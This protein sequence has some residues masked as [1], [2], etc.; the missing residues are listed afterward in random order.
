MPYIRKSL[1]LA[2][3]IL[4]LLH[5]ITPALACS[6]GGNIPLQDRI[7]ASDYVAKVRV[8]ETDEVGRNVIVE[9]ESYLSGEAGPSHLFIGGMPPS[10]VQRT[11]IDRAPSEECGGYKGAFDEL[12][13]GDTFY[14]VLAHTPLG[15]YYGVP[16][17]LFNADFIQFPTPDSTVFVVFPDGEF[18]DSVTEPEFLDIVADI[19]GSSPLPPLP[20]S[21]YP[22]RSPL[23]ITTQSGADY[24][25]PLD[26]GEPLLIT[27]QVLSDVI[28]S[29]YMARTPW[30]MWGERLFPLLAS[31]PDMD[32]FALHPLNTAFLPGEDRILLT[33]GRE[34]EL[35]GQQILVSPAAEAAA[36][37]NGDT[38]NVYLL[39]TFIP[40]LHYRQPS[41]NPFPDVTEVPYL[42]GGI[43]LDSAEDAPI[44]SAY[45]AWSP[46]ARLLAYSDAQSLWLWDALGGESPRLL[47]P[48]EG[49]SIPYARYFSPGGRYLAVTA[50]DRA[51]NLDL[52]SGGEHPDGQFSSD[53]RLLL[54]LRPAETPGF[55]DLAIQQMT[56]P[57]EYVPFGEGV[58]VRQAEWLEDGWFLTVQCLE[59]EL[60]TCR[61]L[62][63]KVTGETHPDGKGG[64]LTYPGT[65]FVVEDGSIATLVNGDTITFNG[66][67]L[68]LAL[69]SPIARIRWM[70]TLFYHRR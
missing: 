21:P 60:S 55:Y 57:G 22:A 69:D 12:H 17:V 29:G 47:L 59:Q 39:R 38:L 44:G 62:P 23:L 40:F 51:Y 33:W 56:P 6:G 52:I 42:L 67:L 11:L 2:A 24:L 30:S 46:D 5:P 66:T 27:E 1:F 68:D 15:K 9:V 20:D 36:V 64:T 32:C 35:V 53:D 14:A 28:L 31:C 58:T 18:D 25:L 13:I 37:W 45:A 26:G 16:E 49:G 63:M 50:G 48:T 54:A 8:V 7:E 41:D 65:S 70:P 19:T 4:L 43:N 61:V 3:L 10:H 34:G